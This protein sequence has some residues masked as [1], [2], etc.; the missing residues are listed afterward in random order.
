[1]AGRY[2]LFDPIASGGM[3]EVVLGRMRGA[4]GF[5][6][7]VAVKRLLP[8][9]AGVRRF[10]EMFVD[11]AR[12]AARVRHPNVVPIL[13]LVVDE[14]APFL[15]ME[16]VL[17]VTLAELLRLVAERGER[18][19]PPVVG[20]VL[21]D[22]LEGL[23]AAHEA[24]GERGE[25]LSIVHRDVSPQNVLVG[26]DGV[27]RVLDFGVARGGG[28]VQAST[29][30]AL[31]GKVLYMAPEVL[32]SGEASPASDV[33]SAGVVLWEALT[34]RR[35]FSGAGGQLLLAELEPP[36]RAVPGLPPAIDGVV[37]RAMSPVPEARFATGR[38]MGAAVSRALA[39]TAAETSAWVQ[40]VAAAELAARAALVARAEQ[41][42]EAPSAAGAPTSRG[43]EVDVWKLLAPPTRRR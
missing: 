19:P 21:R 17:G 34:A 31:K 25:P 27:A 1:M 26:A 22:T 3:A 6:L 9:H 24:R 40:H 39:G 10:V 35:P 23:H 15:V 32:A 29:G 11:E 12:L 18:I 38:E 7:T 30:G 16:H 41:A 42:D 20:S 28:R 14:G 43:G 4:A 37:R 8:E 33:Y 36:S 13:D 2:V 5:A